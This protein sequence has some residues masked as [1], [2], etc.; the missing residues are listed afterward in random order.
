MA[1][2]ATAGQK[3]EAVLSVLRGESTVD[4]VCR[5]QGIL[6]ATYR[7]WQRAVVAGRHS[8]PEATITD[9]ALARVN[10]SDFS[11]SGDYSGKAEPI[12]NSYDALLVR[13]RQNQ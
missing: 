6:P 13:L 8:D 5:R 2:R 3:T 12:L 7:R 4:E 9:S 1:R 11:N 10:L